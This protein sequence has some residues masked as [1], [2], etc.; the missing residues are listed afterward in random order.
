MVVV[1]NFL[2]KQPHFCKISIFLHFGVLG[3]LFDKYLFQG[4]RKWVNFRMFLILPEP[5][6]LGDHKVGPHTDCVV[7]W[8]TVGGI[9]ALGGPQGPLQTDFGVA[10]DGPVTVL[11]VLQDKFC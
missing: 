1:G 5:G 4:P 8:D 10:Q 2:M 3:G 9:Q 11:A 7:S 6:C